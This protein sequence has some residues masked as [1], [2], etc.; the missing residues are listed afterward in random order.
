MTWPRPPVLFPK[1]TLSAPPLLFSLVWIQPV[2][3]GALQIFSCFD[4]SCLRSFLSRTAQLMHVC[5][6]YLSWCLLLYLCF[7]WLSVAGCVSHLI[8]SSLLFL[9]TASRSMWHLSLGSIVNLTLW[10]F[11][12][13]KSG[14]WS[15]PMF[16]LFTSDHWHLTFGFHIAIQG[17]DFCMTYVHP[18]IIPTWAAST[19]LDIDWL[20]DGRRLM[21]PCWNEDEPVHISFFFR[22]H[23]NIIMRW[24]L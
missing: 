1:T 13:L 16:T 8:C 9:L 6:D 15:E 11:S 5:L 17:E 2:R 10:V 20:V 3:Y 18:V 12:H 4:F 22:G 19:T 24:R 7:Q 14:P 21:S 23:Y